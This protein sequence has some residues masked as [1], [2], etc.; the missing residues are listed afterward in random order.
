MAIKGVV[1]DFN[2]T[3]FWDTHLHNRAWDL[4]LERKGIWL[5]DLE[6][7]RKIHG[8][9][10]QDIFRALFQDPLTD[11][12]IKE[13]IEEK[14]GI[15]QSLCLQ[16]NLKLA[17]GASNFLEFLEK[18]HIPFTIATA[19]GIENVEFYFEHLKLSRHFHLSKVVYNDGSFPG[20]PHPQIFLNAMNN[21]ELIASE[22][23]IFED[24]IAGILSAENASAGRIIIVDSNGEDYGRWDYQVIRDFSDV[25]HTIFKP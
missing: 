5:T 9:Y 19:S 14:E 2:G 12:Q 25:D 13:Y 24:S 3:L 16:F 20:K 15:Y 21:L 18:S 22:T 8:K 1:F 23:L 17:P 4:F 6:K 11:S 10:N 7:N